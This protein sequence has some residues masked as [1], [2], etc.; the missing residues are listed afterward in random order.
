VA[1][2]T[3]KGTYLKANVVTN[4]VEDVQNAKAGLASFDKINNLSDDDQNTE[5]MFTEEEVSNKIKDFF[6]NLKRQWEAGDFSELGKQLADVIKNAL[7]SI[8]WE[9][10]QAKAEKVGKSLATLLNGLFSDLDLAKTLGNTFAEVLNSIVSAINGF[11][12][13]FDFG[14]AGTFT[15]ELLKSFLEGIKWDNIKKAADK[16]GTGLAEYLNAIFKDKKLAEDIGT[17]IAEMINTAVTFAKAF[18]TKFD[19]KELGTFITTLVKN[20]LEKINWKDIKTCA[21]KLGKGISTT[22]NEIFRDKK[23]A[24]DVGKTLGETLNSIFIFA[25]NTLILT[26]WENGFQRHFTA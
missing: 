12:S 14:Q 22:L 6:E 10:V 3:G 9:E 13:K 23:L 7:K 5:N 18:L 16:L 24:Q 20:T 8:P 15:T 26:I 11:L 19:F 17:S 1:A 21:E 4:A 2:L 25:F